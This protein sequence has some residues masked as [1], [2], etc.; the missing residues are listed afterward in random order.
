MIGRTYAKPFSSANPL[1][2]PVNEGAAFYLFQ[3]WW[4]VLVLAENSPYNLIKPV[5]RRCY[6]LLSSP[7][8]VRCQRRLPR[9][10]QRPRLVLTQHLVD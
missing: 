10:P 1:P 4:R 9:Q 5:F 2:V 3:V 7:T 8:G 6:H